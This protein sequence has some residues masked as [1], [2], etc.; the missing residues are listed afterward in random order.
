MGNSNHTMRKVAFVGLLILQCMTSIRLSAQPG[1]V[2]SL[3]GDIN[4]SSTGTASYSIPIE[5]VPGMQG[6]QPNLS[7]TYGSATG[8]GLLGEKWHL[9]GLSSITRIP[10]THY[11]DG[12]TGGV[13][14]D[15]NDRFALDGSRLMKLSSGNYAASNAVYGTEVESFTRVTLKE[16][17][18]T[19]SQCFIAVTD[20]GHVI[21]YGNTADSKQM[22]GGKVV[23]WFA[24]KITDADG[25]YMTISYGQNEGEIWPE[26]INYTGNASTGM[27][28]YAKVTF[29]YMT[30]LHVNFL[31]SGG[32]SLRE[33]KL[34][35]GI[36]IYFGTE[37]V[38][39]YAFEYTCD[40]ST[41]LSNVILKNASGAELTRT[42]IGWGNDASGNGY[43]PMSSLK[44][45]VILPF[46]YNGD[47]YTD[48]FMYTYEDGVSTW[49]VRK[50]D[51]NGHFS[52]VDQYSGTINAYTF[53]VIDK[54]GDGQDEIGFVSNLPDG[55]F[56]F[57]CLK[58]TGN[59]AS[60]I[61]IATSSSAHFLA[62][63]FIGKGGT[64][65]IFIHKSGNNWSVTN[66]SN[67]A[68]FSVPKNS[69]VSVCD[70]NGNG[71][72]DVHVVHGSTID[73]YEYDN[74]GGI[75]KKIL[76]AAS[77]PKASKKEFFC[78]LNGDGKSD[79]IFYS[80]YKWYQMMSTGTGYT[81][82]AELPFYA[83]M[84]SSGGP[85]FD[86][87]CCDLNGDGKDDVAQPYF[88]F[89]QQKLTMHVYFSRGYSGGSF[90]YSH[91]SFI[92][93]DIKGIFT[94]H[95]RFADLNGDGKNEMFYTGDIYTTPVL[96]N[97]SEKRAHDLVT[98][99]TNGLGRTSSLEYAFVSTPSIGYLG[100]EARKLQ[101]PLVSKLK[102][103]DGLGGFN[104]TL[105]TYGKAVFDF[106]RRQFLGFLNYRTLY[107]GI[108]SQML[109]KYN[110]VH[111][112]L[113]LE[114][115]IAFLNANPRDLR[116]GYIVD[117]SYWD[118][119]RV[120]FHHHEVFN[121]IAYKDLPYGTFLPYFSI[122]STVNRLE[123]TKL[124]THCWLDA[125]G[126]ISKKSVVST[127]AMGA[128]MDWLTRDSTNYTYTTV[129]LPNGRQARRPGTV[130]TRKRRKGF[131]QV[132][133]SK[134]SHTYSSGRLHSVT[135][136]D[137]D[138]L[139]GETVYE[140]NDKGLLSSETYTPNGLPARTRSYGYDATGRFMTV[141][142]DVLGHNTS[143]QYDPKTG[144]LV[145]ETDANGLTTSYEHDALGHLTGTTRPDQTQC[146]ISYHWN[147]TP[148]FSNA[149]YYSR[150]TET[151]QPERKKYYDVLGRLVHTYEKGRGY[152]DIIFNNTGQ[153]SRKTTTPYPSPSMNPNSKTWSLNLYD[154]YR[155]IIWQTAPY[156][157]LSFSYPD[158][159][160]GIPRPYTVT[161]TDNI[162]NVQTSKT[163]DAGGRLVEAADAGGTISYSYGYQTLSGKVRDKTTI[164]VGG[165]VTTVL[166]DI[167]GNRVS[168][169]DPNAGTVTSAYNAMNQLTAH[170]D[171]NGNLAEYTYDLAGRTLQVAY[172][173]GQ[174]SET[175]S[176][177]YDNAAGKGIGRIAAVKRNGRNECLYTYDNLGR[178]IS[179]KVFDGG[180]AY[181]HR[182]AY[183]ALGQL[184][185]FTYPDGFKIENT[186][187]RYGELTEIRNAADNTLIYATDTRNMFR[188]P[189]RCRFGNGTGTEY[190]YNAYGRMTGIRNG[191]ITNSVPPVNT[192]GLGNP[193]EEPWVS[194]HIDTRYRD[195]S[196]A[197]D[198]R[199]FI[200]T[201]TDGKT[202]QSEAY[203]YDNLD[204]L[205][206]YTVNGAT[207]ATFAYNSI[208]NITSNSRVGS[209][210]Y[211]S[212]R[213]NA[214]TGITGNAACPIPASQCDVCYNFRNKPSSIAEGGY[215][216]TFDYNAEG[217]R[218]H[219][220]YFK[221]NMMQKGAARISEVHGIEIS[222]QG[223]RR[224][225]YIYADGKIVAVHVK[226]GSSDSLYYVLTDHLG[227]WNMVTDAGKDIVQ[228]THFDPWGN[229]MSHTSWNTPQTQ[230]SFCFD[231]GFTGH[232]HYD[233]FKI[234]NANA[235]LYDPV[236]GRFFSPDPFVQAPGFTQSYNRYSYCLNNPV[237]FTDPDGEVVWFVPVI[238]GAAIGAYTGGVIAN[239]GQYNPGQWNYSSGKTWG[240]VLGGAVVG[241]LAGLAGG[242]IAGSGIPMAN[243]AAIAGSSLINS[244]GTY[245]YTG[246][247][248][249]I[250]IS[251]GVLS[252]DFTNNDLGY[253]GKKG[254]KWYENLGYGLGAL[255]NLSDMASLLKG[256]GQNIKV[257][258]ASTKDGND[259][260]GHSSI[261][262]ESAGSLVSVGPDSQVGKST[263]LSQ[264]WKNSFKGA[265]MG[266]DTYLGQKGT[267]SVELNNVSTAAIS[268]YASG[269]TRWDLL[270][271]SC[272]GHTSRAL[273]TAGVPN[274]YLFHPH[275]LNA[276]LLIR[277]L[278]IYSSPYLYQIP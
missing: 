216:I 76:N 39:Q 253:L 128:T 224:L 259:W 20:E 199:G 195:L 22:A 139:I 176:Y 183:N 48:L 111:R 261:T 123:N 19:I 208:G 85:K 158:F 219:T 168:I 150:M 109:F 65:L 231:R 66:S 273:W 136:S 161:T 83:D 267:W 174:E 202:G 81:N 93:A 4:V 29:Q 119:E 140:Y 257:N 245:A 226:R 197:Y 264:T 5:V 97:F 260:W 167:R 42:A 141:Q 137:T 75:F 101:L 272:V 28:T 32:Q 268:K 196:Y 45:Y 113:N 171:A 189:T 90:N 106:E 152:N 270:L 55:N 74:N 96:V 17:P 182:Y 142:T 91:T 236:I 266:W 250:S 241:G 159:S 68:S 200:A 103:P 222:S 207:A 72:S 126:R 156:Q 206:S 213:P 251:F 243:T 37:L 16:N 256:G 80:D 67:S 187:N 47:S 108:N 190:R 44:N 2:G 61:G 40:R 88:D 71:K 237:M 162:R 77:T 160:T 263:S 146:N 59:S 27:N 87:M 41:R 132:P 98:S 194:Y 10:Q 8:R 57:K 18:G 82:G 1:P 133:F 188:Q 100:Y 131:S 201:R 274:V 62:G 172:S 118:T 53:F 99:F 52:I 249:P 228:Q 12:N 115:T 24:N 155:R 215:R 143:S 94:S 203:T 145:S 144:L 181:N 129:T 227:S 186:Y 138:G 254:N 198:S 127:K 14:L 233:R 210:S 121:T 86:I 246:G 116:S 7:V 135:V 117:P 230:T 104:Q 38:R 173:K 258:S 23:S 163:F 205:T 56:A 276:Q 11:P 209:Y 218:L 89:E 63:D 164:T 134:T 169:Q 35:S 124:M 51:G 25:N 69:H 153:I 49:H 175:V 235:R 105:F 6:M 46:N 277:Q 125:E 180:T 60:T 33:A 239:K 229:R 114:Q 9:S 271:N 148:N 34:L 30:D 179:R 112:H 15:N 220:R 248:T 217:T 147:D 102:E 225:D 149:V 13:N 130:T 278:G 122:S 151:G 43:L 262:D 238:I 64:Q 84:N 214:V 265:N 191:D 26:T 223:T 240:Y 221:G 244:V 193:F 120:S 78:D 269:V 107:N 92:R 242:A 73:I 252:Y 170:T 211:G 232:E 166:S 234:L 50:G 157:N 21:E 165:Q 36:N 154:R 177:V 275:F 79:F 178:T 255:A 184:Q 185:Y 3:G 192:Y 110:T 54:D 58:F 204:R 31:F 212:S 247:Q 95:Y 70:F